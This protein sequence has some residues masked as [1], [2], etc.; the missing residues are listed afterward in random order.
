MRFELIGLG[1]RYE[2]RR[3]RGIEPVQG[4]LLFLTLM[5]IALITVWSQMPPA[6]KDVVGP[7]EF[8]A[9]RALADIEAITAGGPHP[10]GSEAQAQV[11]EYLIQRLESIGYSPQVCSEWITQTDWNEDILVKNI[12]AM[13][14]GQQAG[15]AV[16]ITAHYDSVHTGPGAMDD[17]AG[18]A[19]LLQI[20]ESLANRTVRNP[21][22]FLL[23]DGEE[24]N[25]LGAKAFV[26]YSPL[27]EDVAVVLNL[28]SRGSSGLGL[29]FEMGEGNRELIKL[30][31]DAVDR[32]AASSAFYALY[33]QLP[34]WTDFTVY[35]QVGMTGYNIANIGTPETYHTAAD[36]AENVNLGT[37]QHIGDT[38]MALALRLADADLE[39]LRASED[40]IFFDIFTR[41]LIHY[42]QKHAIPLAI[43][44]LAISLLAWA[45]LG[46]IQPDKPGV[47][48]MVGSA[49]FVI[50]TIAAFL[51]GLAAIRLV[52]PVLP[53]I[54]ESGIV[55]QH[56]AASVAILS[57]AAVGATA[58]LAALER[59]SGI[60]G[61]V[62]GALIW[63]NAAVVA[64]TILLPGVSYLFVFP[65][66]VCALGLLALSFMDPASAWTH[67]IA[68][69]PGIVVASI[70]WM[71]YAG[72]L[73]LTGGTLMFLP[74]IPVVLLASL[75]GPLFAG[76]RGSI[77]WV[78]VVSCLVVSAV[79]VVV[80][81]W[82]MV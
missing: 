49:A 8:S 33:E 73:T 32:P 64:S 31:A 80:T 75:A 68:M 5:A 10:T 25:V 63:W 62:G 82:L 24:Y 37:L 35:K 59:W 65:T 22:I 61:L 6:P 20:A 30:Y 3:P 13:L 34:V 48:L 16:M 19:V 56:P 79:A 11:R 57:A 52:S 7:D 74:I 60:A 23:S 78:P 17:G 67:L 72:L 12:V 38:A 54:P 21:V 40:S 29:L 70:F 41:T 27:A 71:P 14:D 9:T 66:I 18:V 58:A 46:S 77:R 2:R 51:C 53:V 55:V 28:E 42:P 81:H 45:R 15:P 1:M 69:L 26:A 76:L 44:A 47:D 43:L 36:S 50:S 4:V 39:S